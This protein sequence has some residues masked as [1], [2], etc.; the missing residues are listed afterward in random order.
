MNAKGIEQ[1]EIMS[2]WYEDI[3]RELEREEVLAGMPEEYSF[4]SE[5]D[6]D[7]WEMETEARER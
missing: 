6:L 7:A 3:A 1:R 5:E 4:V 2:D